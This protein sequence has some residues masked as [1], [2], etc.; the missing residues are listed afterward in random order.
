MATSTSQAD[1]QRHL[2]KLIKS[3]EVALNELKDL[4]SSRGSR[5]LSKLRKQKSVFYNKSSKMITEVYK[6]PSGVGLGAASDVDG[7]GG[8]GGEMKVEVGEEVET[9][10][11]VGKNVAVSP[12]PPLPPSSPHLHLPYRLHLEPH[13]V[14]LRWAWA[15]MFRP[16]EVGL[17]AALD[18]DGRGGGGG[19]M[20]V[21][22]EVEVTPQHSD[23]PPAPSEPAD[24]VYGVLH[25]DDVRKPPEWNSV[26]LYSVGV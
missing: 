4:S 10:P 3:E 7:S 23:R 26:R 12:P 14:P 22:E 15:K 25:F 8:G 17:G 11:A 16:T 1:V 5:S 18:V 21:G 13:R 20:K 24:C 6:R 19:E 9:V 2:L